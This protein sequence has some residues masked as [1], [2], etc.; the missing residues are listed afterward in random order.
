MFGSCKSI[1]RLYI[2]IFTSIFRINTLHYT[3]RL[4]YIYIHNDADI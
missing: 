1:Y 2:L 3:L 4:H